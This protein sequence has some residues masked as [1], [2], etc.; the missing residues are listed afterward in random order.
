MKRLMIIMTE[1]VLSLTLIGA[2]LTPLF[3][4]GCATSSPLFN[5]REN[6]AFV[7]VEKPPTRIILSGEYDKIDP[8]S[9]IVI[10]KELR[11]HKYYNYEFDS[12][13]DIEAEHSTNT[14]DRYNSTHRRK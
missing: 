2:L 9:I 13:I 4:Q 11:H 6:K 5:Y 1:V 7:I 8:N 14:T 3:I 12:S 10:L